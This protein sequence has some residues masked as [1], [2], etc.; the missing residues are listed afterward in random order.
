[1]FLQ[2][3]E[4]HKN[5]E[6]IYERSN[7]QRSN[8]RPQNQTNGLKKTSSVQSKDGKERSNKGNTSS[9]T[10]KPAATNSKRVNDKNVVGNGPKENKAMNRTNSKV[11]KESS[12]VNSQHVVEKKEED[13]KVEQ[14][15]AAEVK[16]EKKEGE[17]P[18]KEENQTLLV[19]TKL[20]FA[21][22]L[23]NS[24]EKNSE[25]IKECKEDQKDKPYKPV[26]FY[27]V[28]EWNSRIHV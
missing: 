24:K 26:S 10:P 11:K 12:S 20:S 25:I 5:D 3:I 28:W 27:M 8:S 6:I 18:K 2:R 9:L 4:N 15:S 23:K 1:M 21:S 14:Q 17:E 7:F 19:S 16:E 13:K 22:L